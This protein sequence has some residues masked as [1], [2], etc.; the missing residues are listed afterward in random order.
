MLLFWDDTGS[1][2]NTT[3][4]DRLLNELKGF[5]KIIGLSFFLSRQ[6][7]NVLLFLP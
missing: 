5:K 6:V 2:E 1:P 7:L 4:M 3:G